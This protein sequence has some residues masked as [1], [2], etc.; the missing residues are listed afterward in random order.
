M[1]YEKE[2]YEKYEYFIT[3]IIINTQNYILNGVEKYKIAQ[4]ENGSKE[5]FERIENIFLKMLGNM[6]LLRGM[7]KKSYIKK[8][9]LEKISENIDI[10]LFDEE[11]KNMIAL[12]YYKMKKIGS[13]I[14]VF[15]EIIE[16]IFF[17]V[18]FFYTKEKIL[19]YI[20]EEK[21]MTTKR[22]MEALI[23]I[24]LDINYPIR[25]FWNNYF[26]EIDNN[27]MMI[28]DRIEIY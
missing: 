3:P 28:I 24:F 27:K 18:E 7:N 2:F 10:T 12:Y 20:K 26:G 14:E 6:D 4:K 15:K 21:S 19:L 25:I 23:A 17:K 1:L 11:E 16:K 22:K 9:I 8:I 13:D 5:N